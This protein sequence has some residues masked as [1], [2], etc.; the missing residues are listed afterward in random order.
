MTQNRMACNWEIKTLPILG[1]YNRQRFL[2]FSPED[3]ANWVIQKGNSTTKR[4]FSMYPTMGRAHIN[5]NG[6]NQLVFNAQPR[7]I[8]KSIDYAYIIVGNQVF[9]V[10]SNYEQFPIGTIGSLG[11]NVYFC[12]LVVNTIV[13]ACF[14]DPQGIYIYQEDV[15]K[16]NKVD[17]PLAPG[18]LTTTDSNGNTV[19]T[20]PGAIA[21][22]GNRIVV[23]CL[24]SSQ[25]CL[26]TVNLLNQTPAQK[27]AGEPAQFNSNYCFHNAGSTPS[28]FAQEDGIIQ[29]MGVLNNTLYIFCDYVTGVWSNN[30]AVFPGTG[31]YFPWKKN[32]TYN[33]NFGIA[34][35]LS[36]D[37]D[38]GFLTF[39]AQN[40]DGLLQV[41][42]SSG[43]TP[44]P[45]SSKAID[46]LFQQY[47][48]KYGNNSPF[49]SGNASGFLYQYENTIFYRLSG[50][51]YQN[52]GILDDEIAANSIEYNFENQS[53]SRCIELNGNRNRIERHIYFNNQHLV[54]VAGDN[55]VYEMGGQL[56][57]NELRNPLQNDA[58]AQDAYL[59][60]PF[61]YERISY[62][63]SEP[64]YAEFETEYVEIDFCFGESNISY[65][66]NPFQ[67]AQFLIGEAADS[68]GKPIPIITETTTNLNDPI[69]VIADSGNTP[70]L[71]ERTYNSL[72][73]PHIELYYSDDG[74]V[75][76]NSADDRQFSDQGHYQWKMRWYQLGCSRNRVYKLVAVSPVPI[77]VL[78]GV[79]NVRRISGGAN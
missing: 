2:Q 74:G 45:I 64:D 48:N 61:R 33:W 49:L 68:D 52:F 19:V 15:K 26:S 35:P 63:I 46:V 59:A 9:Q 72:F 32:T 6:L 27:A 34:D 40:S 30:P 56:Y 57:T 65:S 36:L 21:A 39:L 38:F 3:A 51:N 43:A 13:F 23:S 16:W 7:F 42:M 55:T 76:F 70:Q 17:D 8:F 22:F 62:I 1:Q 29:Q 10:N 5:A 47:A 20:Q 18:Q 60:Y 11:G 73:N 14:T 25:F 78:G 75:S 54:T 67:N 41:M 37:I 53:W 79:M 71:N 58:Q 12:Y 77:V 66:D 44:E 50:G 31:A 28:V 24:G 69:Y 4:Q